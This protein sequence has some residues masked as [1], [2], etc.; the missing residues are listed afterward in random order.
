[1]LD[2]L[3]TSDL[4]RVGCSVAVI[5]DM[6]VLYCL[7]DGMR[8]SQAGP[9]FM[10]SSEEIKLLTHPHGWSPILLANEASIS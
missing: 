5:Q 9:R 8:A 7:C 10:L 4:L 1:M 2:D 6:N 3:K